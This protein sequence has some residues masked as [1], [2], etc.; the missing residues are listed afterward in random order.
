MELSVTQYAKRL[1]VTRQ[2]VL[3]QISQNRLAPNVV[4]KK[5]GTTW[6]LTI[7]EPNDKK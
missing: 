7:N 3:S 6:V 4:A 1:G 2:A 5:I